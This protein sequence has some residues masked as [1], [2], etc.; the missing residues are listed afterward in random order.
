MTHGHQWDYPSGWAPHQI[1]AWVGLSQYGYTEEA[2]R[3][4]Y[5][6]LYTL[7][8]VFV[9]YNGMVCEKYDVT[10][11]RAQHI[12][13]AEYG[14]QGVNFS[15]VPREGFGWTNASFVYGLSFL[16]DYM[17]KALDVCAPY[18]SLKYFKRRG[19]DGQD[20]QLVNKDRHSDITQQ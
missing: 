2:A 9:D 13:T 11:E 20:A 7:L 3:L 6:W 5:R 18:E 17:Q 12:V 16:S 10:R 14:N 1:L 19:T 8:T 15:G 4:A